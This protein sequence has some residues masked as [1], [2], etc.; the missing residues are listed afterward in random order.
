M[1]DDR[2]FSLIELIV[3]MAI[4]GIIVTFGV[5]KSEVLY[6]YRAQEAYKKV[7]STL[8]TE[9]VQV[10]SYS[11]LT[12]G[13]TSVQDSTGAVTSDVRNNGVYIE[14]YMDKNMVYTK[15]Y[16]KGTPKEEKGAKVAGKG[17]TIEYV[18]D[19]ATVTLADGAP[20]RL[21]YD[22]ST[23][24]FLPCKDGKYVTEISILGG[25][26]EYTI[27]LMKKTGKAVRHGK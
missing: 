19:G 4:M 6:S 3:I 12:S 9:K 15:T 10:L 26:R 23:G 2:G 21:S 5:V 16:V 25:S 18:L 20:L 11:A 7:L 14:F 8:T 27:K 1:K 22:R 13:N 17:V 24:A